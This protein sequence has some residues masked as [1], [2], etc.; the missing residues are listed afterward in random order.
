MRICIL[1]NGRKNSIFGR[2]AQYL[3]RNTPSFKSA[4]TFY[5]NDSRKIFSLFYFM[6]K[7]LCIRPKIVYVE[8]FAL[9]GC[10]AAFLLK[11]ILRFRSIVS[12]GDDYFNII[13][14]LHGNFI[15]YL[16]S[17]VEL[18]I[19]KTA[20]TIISLSPYQRDYLLAKGYKR[21]CYVNIGVDTSI[22]KPLNVDSLKCRLGLKDLLVIGLVG[23]VIWNKKYHYSYGWE[24]IE[25][26]NILKEK[27]VKGLIV[28]S[29][30]GITYLKELAQSYGVLENIIFVG[31][32]KYE[33]VPKYINCMDICFSTQSNNMVGRMRTPTKL[34]EYLACGK[35]VISSNVG[36]GQIILKDIGRLIP[37]NGIKDNIY[38]VKAS[39]IVNDVL[40]NRSILNIAKKGIDI[41]KDG[42][43][44]KQLSLRLEEIIKDE[45][46]KI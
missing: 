11:P 34:G 25:I 28:G 40:L 45:K 21:V 4:F 18:L 27:P 10:F 8:A 33:D 15:G 42:F 17:V 2:R 35:F 12:V 22:F 24:I 3:C 37:Y 31:K 19:Y 26:L 44:F 30:D 13:K 23:S 38:P 39:K 43:D 46:E 16:A 9:S 20:N 32:V 5:R 41:A 14:Q 1:V 6:Y 36:Y 7:L 29:G